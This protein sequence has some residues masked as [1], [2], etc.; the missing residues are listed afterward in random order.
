MGGEEIA[1]PDGISATR[2]FAFFKTIYRLGDIGIIVFY[3]QV[4]DILLESAKT[5]YIV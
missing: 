2:Y 3:K 5:Q 1:R 4:R